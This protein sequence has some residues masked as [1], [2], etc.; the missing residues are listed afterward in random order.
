MDSLNPDSLFDTSEENL[1]KIQFISNIID[2]IIDQTFI[3]ILLIHNK[4]NQDIK[5]KGKE[6][7]RKRSLLTLILNKVFLL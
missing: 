1:K 7:G 4:D 5:E 3:K 6:E 2:F